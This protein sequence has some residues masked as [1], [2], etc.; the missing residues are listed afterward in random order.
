VAPS[1]VSWRVEDA[2]N[3]SPSLLQE[4]VL[5]YSVE[6]LE[7]VVQVAASVAT[8]QEIRFAFS[9]LPPCNKINSHV[10][11]STPNNLSQEK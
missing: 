1:E 3:L 2:P 7:V 8:R 6:V 4:C 9:L 11:I 10:L 5:R